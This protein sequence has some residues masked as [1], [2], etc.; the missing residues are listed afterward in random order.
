MHSITIAYLFIK[1]QKHKILQGQRPK[2]CTKLFTDLTKHNNYF[3]TK[4]IKKRIF[5]YKLYLIHMH[6]NY[7]I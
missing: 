1:P 4:I 6:N 7:D 2:Q 5:D 3:K